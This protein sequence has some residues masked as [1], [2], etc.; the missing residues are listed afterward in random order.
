MQSRL[1]LW[2]AARN[3]QQLRYGEIIESYKVGEQFMSSLGSKSE[4]RKMMEAAPGPRL[5][6]V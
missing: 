4:D 3:L 6:R 2:K 5:I 1:R